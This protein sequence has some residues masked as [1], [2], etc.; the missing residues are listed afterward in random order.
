L[1]LLTTDSLGV[2]PNPQDTV[3]ARYQAIRTAIIGKMN[4][5]ALT[6]TFQK[7]HAPARTLIQA[8]AS[9]KELLGQQDLRQLLG[10]NGVQWAVGA[11]QRN[12]NV[13]RFLAGLAIRSWDLDKFVELL[14]LRTSETPRIVIS[15][16]RVSNGLDPQFMKWL[17]SKSPA[18]HQRLYAM[19][20]REL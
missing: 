7:T 11:T 19:L 6:P 20:R 12:S 3:P 4:T 2:L 8:K 13:D 16:S 15:A 5:E 9:L 14:E 18:W 1:K 10:E 17:A